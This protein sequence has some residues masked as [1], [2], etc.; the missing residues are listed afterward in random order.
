MDISK[1]DLIINDSLLAIY[2][3][4]YAMVSSDSFVDENGMKLNRFNGDYIGKIMI[5][6]NLVQK[7]DNFY[8]LT[9]KGI[10]IVESGGYLKK[11]HTEK[12]EINTQQIT[13]TINVNGSNFG[14]INQDSDFLESPI[15]I[16]TKPAPSNKPDTK[17]LF[18]IITSNPWF[19]GVAMCLLAAILNG[20]RVMKF[21]NNILNNF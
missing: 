9:R 7:K 6:R 3:S 18:K 1:I 8:E 21:I 20:N 5:E 19:T 14:V 11:R 2:N 12:G 13:K 17:S 15:N 10:E 16:K 4:E